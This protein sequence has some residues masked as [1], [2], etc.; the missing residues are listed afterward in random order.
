MQ[1]PL[2]CSIANPQRPTNPYRCAQEFGVGVSAP[3]EVQAVLAAQAR[4]LQRAMA[5]LAADLY[6]SRVHLLLE[7]LQNADDCRW[8]WDQ[9]CV[10]GVHYECA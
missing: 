4:R 2:P 6:A 3:P 9:G 7:L 10:L 5:R 8:L 1:P